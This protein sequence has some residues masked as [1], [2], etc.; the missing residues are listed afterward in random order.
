MFKFDF[1]DEH[2][3]SLHLGIS[4]MVGTLG[5]NHPIMNYYQNIRL[6]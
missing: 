3:F 4:H 2:I 5:P 6:L 1:K